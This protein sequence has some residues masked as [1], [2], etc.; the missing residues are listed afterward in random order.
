MLFVVEDALEHVSGVAC[1]DLP[2]GA[3]V[4]SDLYSICDV[5][6]QVALGETMCFSNGSLLT[7]Q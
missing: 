7:G 4:A 5:K 1:S 2:P 3:L 6:E